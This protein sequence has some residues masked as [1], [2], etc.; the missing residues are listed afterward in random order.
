MQ[1][2]EINT[3]KT[4]SFTGIYNNRILK[5]GLEF[6]ANNGSLFAAGTS[7][8]L[9]TAVRPV[10]ILMTPKTDTENKKYACAKSFASSAIGYLL[11]L[12][13]SLPI[14]NSVKNIDNNPS[15]FLKN[16]TIETYKKSEKILSHSKQYKFA[17]QL[18]KLGLGFV[19]AIPKSVM[20]CATI[21]PIMNFLF[22]KKQNNKNTQQNDFKTVTFKGA[23]HKGTE[24]I[25]KGIGKILDTK[26]MQKFSDKYYDTNF[27]QHIISLTDILLTGTFIKQTQNSKKIE[28]SRKKALMYNAGIST[29]LSIVGGY[30]LNALLNKP[31]EKFIKKFSEINK[32]D[33]KLDKYIEGIKIAKPVLILGGIY[34][35]VIPFISTF[36]AD[37]FDNANQKV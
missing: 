32:T 31:T 1:V 24:F 33:P 7:L 9:S 36:L 29:G 3:Q 5:K 15:K 34:Y 12:I 19:I 17:T 18:F 4:T 26:F 13:A 37:R 20:T 2:N 11:M 8:V 35:L 28:D 21:P 30:G 16:S 27:E 10:V 23:Y 25:S 14:A 6:A 22:G